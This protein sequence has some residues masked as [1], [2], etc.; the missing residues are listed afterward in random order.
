[1]YIYIYISNNSS[2]CSGAERP[3]SP[4]PGSWQ[5]PGSPI[6]VVL[7]SIIYVYTYIQYIDVYILYHMYIHIVYIHIIPYVERLSLHI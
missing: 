1:M 4:R 5:T 2:L 6:I 3:S 7:E